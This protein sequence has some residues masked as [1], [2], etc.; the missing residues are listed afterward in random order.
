MSF[1][2]N[3]CPS[4]CAAQSLTNMRAFPFVADMG[5]QGQAQGKAKRDCEP[6]AKLQ[7]NIARAHAVL[8]VASTRLSAHYGCSCQA[9]SP[10]PSEDAE[11]HVS[12]PITTE[13][14]EN[15]AD[16][17]ATESSCTTAEASA[18]AA[19]ASA[20]AAEASA[21]AA[22]ASAPAAETSAP[23]TEASAPAAE[24][25][26]P[27]TEASTLATEASA[28]AADASAPLPA[29]PEESKPS[30]AAEMSKPAS[31]P[32]SAGAPAAA[33]DTAM[34]TAED[35][36]APSTQSAT[37][38]KKATAS[39]GPSPAAKKKPAAMAS[40]FG[41]PRPD[42]AF[43][44]F[45]STSLHLHHACLPLIQR[46]S[47]LLGPSPQRHAPRSV[48]QAPPARPPARRARAPR[49]TAA[50]GARLRRPPPPPASPLL[51]QRRRRSK[52]PQVAMRRWPSPTTT[53]PKHGGALWTGPA[54]RRHH[55]PHSS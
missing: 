26:A 31:E 20:P 44:F 19:E 47:H 21:P 37:D 35:K 38:G 7:G 33:E 52:S 45:F 4:A 48:P 1:L 9:Q 42:A 46:P 30:V 8:F 13:S 55:G 22:E 18:P 53:R 12:S 23:T 50:R 40:F 54:A 11:S 17:P 16:K 6:I 29:V 49:W 41:K 24:A 15:A 14:G 2:S 43:F 28:P 32:P 3:A 36:P 34:D 39:A 51:W 25:S 10:Q 27:T 5:S